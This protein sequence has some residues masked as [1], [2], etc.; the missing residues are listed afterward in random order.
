[1][2]SLSLTPKYNTIYKS[3]FVYNPTIIT[4]TII[5]VQHFDIKQFSLMKTLYTGKVTVV[6]LRIPVAKQRSIIYMIFLHSF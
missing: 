6:R 2:I 4:L 1:M 5:N 3:I